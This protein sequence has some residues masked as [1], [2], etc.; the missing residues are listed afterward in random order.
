[1]ETP[2]CLPFR[3]AAGVISKHPEPIHSGAEAKKLVSLC[4]CVYVCVY[5]CVMYH[6]T[7]INYHHGN[8]A[9]YHFWYTRKVWVRRLLKRSMNCWRQESW[10]NLRRYRR[11]GGERVCRCVS[12]CVCVSVWYVC[13]CVV[14]MCVVCM[15]MY[16][17]G[18]YVC[19]MY[20]C[21]HVWMC[22]Y[23]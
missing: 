5:V 17:C 20:V 15:C 21:M 22:E 23:V 3:K 18:M 12:M 13:V 19:G 8:L 14:C 7:H 9:P 4:V 6:D 2:L 10:P 16:V 11:H 1:M